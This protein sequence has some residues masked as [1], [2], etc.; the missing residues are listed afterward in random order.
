VVINITV[1][2]RFSTLCLDCISR[3]FV[4]FRIVHIS[5]E[6]NNIYNVLKYFFFQNVSEIEAHISWIYILNFQSVILLI[7][8]LLMK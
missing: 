2:T 4:V 7:Y 8:Y 3:N 5:I 1:I 6:V